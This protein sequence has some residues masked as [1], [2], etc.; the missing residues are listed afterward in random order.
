MSKR[1]SAST[2]LHTPS[3]H[4]LALTWCVP[5]VRSVCA[6]A[7]MGGSSART[8]LRHR[9]FAIAVVFA[10]RVVYIAHPVGSVPGVDLHHQLCD[11]K[12][13]IVYLLSY[14]RGQMTTTKRGWGRGR[15]GRERGQPPKERQQRCYYRDLWIG[16]MACDI[17]R[18]VIFFH[19]HLWVL[20]IESTWVLSTLVGKP[21]IL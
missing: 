11:N 3:H 5:S 9:R 20:A 16:G 2:P 18:G 15:M 13:A 1:C 19:S 12:V 6:S 10:S 7:H 17:H 4:T 21:Y 14:I 8:I